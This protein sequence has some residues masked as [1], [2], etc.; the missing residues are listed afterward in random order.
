MTVRRLPVVRAAGG[1]GAP[2]ET[3][4]GEVLVARFVPPGAGPDP[5]AE[6]DLF[7]AKGHAAA[8]APPDAATPA[9]PGAEDR[10]AHAPADGEVRA[11]RGR[12]SLAGD[13]PSAARARSAAARA[14]CIEA[15]RARSAVAPARCTAVALVRFSAAARARSAAV[16]ARSTAVVRRRFGVVARPHSVEG[17]AGSSASRARTAIDGSP[18]GRA[19]DGRTLRLPD[20]NP[21]CQR[22]C[23]HRSSRGAYL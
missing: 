20:D 16:P 18:A 23:A 2:R 17:P 6:V 12:G 8:G 22:A 21:K 19:P 11:G 10:R 14:R 4:S 9:A 3:D 5:S 13:D 15:A 1:R 7:S